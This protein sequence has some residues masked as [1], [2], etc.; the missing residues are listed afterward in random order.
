MLA[1]SAA[2]LVIT[3]RDLIERFGADDALERVLL[4]DP[5]LEYRLKRLSA[6][7]VTDADRRIAL[8]PQNLAY[9]IYTSGSTGRPKGVNRRPRLTSYRRPTLTRAIGCLDE[10]PGS[11]FGVLLPA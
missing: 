7:P 11:R 9:L 10:V 3:T 5:V 8:H 4:D 1:D 2:S 6:A